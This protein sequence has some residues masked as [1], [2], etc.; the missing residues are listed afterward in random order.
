[1]LADLRF[2][3][4]QCML[5]E[6][7]KGLLTIGLLPTRLIN[8]TERQIVFKVLKSK[9]LSLDDREDLISPCRLDWSAAGI[10]TLPTICRSLTVTWGPSCTSNVIS[11][12]RPPCLI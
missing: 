9:D 4:Q 6:A 5:N 11:T 2:L 10:S 3:P 8:P 7:L 1:M 12:S